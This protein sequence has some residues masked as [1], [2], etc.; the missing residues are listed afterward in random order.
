MNTFADPAARAAVCERIRRLTPDSPRAWG[1]MTAHQMI[2]H[3]SDGYR[4][5]SGQRAG[6]AV[7]TILSRSVVRFIAIH[8]PMTWPKDAQ[9]VEEADQERGGTRPTEWSR[10][11]AELFRL[12]DDFR[13]LGGI[14]TPSSARSLQTSGMSGHSATP[15]ITCDSSRSECRA[16]STRSVDLPA[17]VLHRAW[18]WAPAGARRPGVVV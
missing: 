17:T 6:R 7:D 5:S 9:T 15:I 3:L 10:D 11:C 14:L 4:M 2:C 12:I 1:R 16:R 13:A 18:M 8:T